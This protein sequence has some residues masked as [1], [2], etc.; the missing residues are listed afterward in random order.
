MQEKESIIWFSVR[1]EIPSL[2]KLF[3][4]KLGTA[5]LSPKVVDSRNGMSSL[6]LKQIIDSYNLSPRETLYNLF[7]K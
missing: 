2:C 5:S 1:E 3:W 6:T 7:T 4:C